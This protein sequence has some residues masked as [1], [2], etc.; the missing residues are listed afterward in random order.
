[1]KSRCS[2][3]GKPN[4]TKLKS[5]DLLTLAIETSG[6]LGSVAVIEAGQVLGEETL[7]LGRQH[8][9]SL[10]PTIGRVLA[11]SGKKARDCQLVAVSV[12]P[13]SYTGLRVGVVCA[14]TL[15]YVANCRLA[16]VDTLQSI[17]CNSPVDVAV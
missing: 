17:A 4:P 14:K 7:E 2:K 1:M 12:G 6:P 3:S 10:I 9:Q 8:G 11:D 5:T 16:A 13:G 15:A